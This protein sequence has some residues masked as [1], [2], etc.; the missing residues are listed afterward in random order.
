MKNRIFQFSFFLA[1]AATSLLIFSCTKDPITVDQV[2]SSEER[3]ID[4]RSA[5]D[6]LKPD[7]VYMYNGVTPT[8]GSQIVV[9][10]STSIV[11]NFYGEHYVFDN[12]EA[13]AQW[14]SLARSRASILTLLDSIDFYQ[15]FE[16]MPSDEST[17]HQLA[18]ISRSGLLFTNPNQQGNVFGVPSWNYGVFNNQASSFLVGGVNVI[19]DRKWFKG[20]KVWLIGVPAYY[21]NLNSEWYNFDNRAESG[22]SL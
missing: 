18:N 6:I 2:I 1:F 5:D 8:L 9:T 17:L 14:A 22:M 11:P 21:D 3:T 16:N 12:D 19:C 7:V 4:D 15:Q 20:A 13:L 10:D